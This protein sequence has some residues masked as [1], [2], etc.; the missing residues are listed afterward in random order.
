MIAWLWART[1]KSPNPAFRTVDVPLVSTVHA[2]HQ[3]GTGGLRT[4]GH[5]RWR[6]PLHGEGREAEDA[7]AAKKGTKLK[8]GA[9]F[10]SAMSGYASSRRTTSARKGRPV[11]SVRGSWPWSLRGTAGES[12]CHQ[13]LSTEAIARKARPE[14][15][16][17]IEFL[18]ASTWLSHRELRHGEWSDLF[19]DRQ[20]VALGTLSRLVEEACERVK[21][22]ALVAGVDDDGRTLVAD[23]AGAAAYTDAAAVYL[24]LA[25]GK[26]ADN[27]STICSWHNGAQ[28]SEIRATFGRQAL[29]MTWDYARGM[30]SQCPPGTFNDRWTCSQRCSRRSSRP[31]AAGTR[32]ARTLPSQ[33]L[34]AGKAVST[35]PPYYDNIG[36]ADLSDF[37]YVWLR[38]CLRRV[39]PG[40]VCHRHCPQER[41]VGSDTGSTRGQGKGGSILRGRHDTGHA[42]AGRKRPPGLS[43]HHLLRFQAV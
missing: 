38:Q 15:K 43:R 31:S 13:C 34:S 9:N 2:L 21:R 27:A 33:S 12:I 19:T 7:E 24:A 17:D 26:F 23:G 42:P 22:D 29:P 20:L 37:F 30:P 35:D 39:F 32:A 36:Y 6:L 18:P 1:V 4:A 14:W 5:P 40:A 8:L 11:E 41:G 3:A 16:P 25:I 28:H 10:S